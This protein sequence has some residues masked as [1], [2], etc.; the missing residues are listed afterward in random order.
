MTKQIRKARKCIQCGCTDG[1][2]VRFHP[3]TK[4]SLG[5]L[6]RKHT[7]KTVKSSE[8][9]TIKMVAGNERK[10]G[11]VVHGGKLKEWVGIG[12]ID[13]RSATSS[14]ERRYPFVVT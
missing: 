13:V 11:K 14:D 2:L 9:T 1:A 10:Y 6:C 12:W 4:L 8:L 3:I 5:I 7:L